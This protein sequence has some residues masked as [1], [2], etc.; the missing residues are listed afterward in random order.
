VVLGDF[1]GLQGDVVVDELLG[2]RHADGVDAARLTLRGEVGV[3]REQCG[4]CVQVTGVDGRDELLDHRGKCDAYC[5]GP[6]ER[7]GR[8]PC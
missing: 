7:R 2:Q 6:L 8:L 5:L 4:Q 3:V 1:E